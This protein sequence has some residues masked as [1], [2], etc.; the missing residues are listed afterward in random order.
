MPART[1]ANATAQA[2]FQAVRDATLALCEPLEVEDHVI[3]SMPDVSPPKW[4]LAHTTWFFETF[5]LSEFVRDYE[6][7]DPNYRYL[8]N[9]YYMA[10]GAQ[11]PR[12]H[13]GLLS[14]PT[15]SE[16]RSYRA[17]V[18]L[19]MQELLASA[20]ADRDEIE[21]R[22]LLGIHHEQQHQELML[23]DIKHIFSVNPLTN[24]HAT[25]CIWRRS[26]WRAAS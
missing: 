14:R 22:T 25:P 2:R 1:E 18:D 11:H 9:S 19:R 17:R 12:P 6:P 8:F 4:H 15:L 24:R 5:I 13:R 10:I 23:M 21:R 26:S 16:I 20:A 7:V 3:Q